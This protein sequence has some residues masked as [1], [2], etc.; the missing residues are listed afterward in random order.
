MQ[1]VQPL[2][3]INGSFFPIP[4]RLHGETF[5]KKRSVI[6]ETLAARGQTPRWPFIEKFYAMR[7]C[8]VRSVFRIAA[9]NSLCLDMGIDV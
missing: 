6:T 2:S 4:A 3:D 5:A 1:L 9:T 7:K 8:K